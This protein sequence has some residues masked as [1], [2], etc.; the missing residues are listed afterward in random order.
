M[1]AS[2][3]V[4]RRKFIKTT[5][6]AAVAAPIVT[7]MVGFSEVGAPSVPSKKR[8]ALVGTG[9]RGSNAW[10]K[11]IVDRYG[12][13]IELVALCDINKGRL[14]YAK[15]H[16]GT[17]APTYHSSD[18]DKMVKE[19]KPDTIVIG[20]TDC[21]HGKY[22]VR[23]MELGCDVL[24]EKPLVTDE[25]QGQHIVDTEIRTGKKITT[26]F[27]ARFGNEAERIKKILLSGELGKVL[28]A[29]FQEYL[30]IDHGASYYRRWHGKNKFSGSLLVHKASHHFDKMNWWLDSEPETVNAFGKLAFYGKNN[31][32]RGKNCRSCSFRSK[33]DFFW[34]IHKYEDKG[35]YLSGEK[36]DGYLRDGCVWDNEIDA[37]DSMTVEVKYAN[38]VLL[39]Y[40]LNSYMPYEGQLIAFNCEKGRLEIRSYHRQPWEVPNAAEVRIT[41]NFGKT[42]T[43]GIQSGEGVHGGADHKLREKL[44]LP[45]QTDELN[46]IAD[47]RSGLL[48]S[49]IGIA[50]ARSIETQQQVRINDLIKFPVSWGR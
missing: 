2:E 20:T 9:T 3:K 30:D 8:Y 48:S 38:D 44:F 7:P 41:K 39:S 49:L 10:A 17:K 15:G 26:T 14:S 1:G 43:F 50:A 47:S 18:F 6:M 35:F 27:N 16:I 40:S 13:Y 24:C 25:V 19:T 28:S 37:Y 45:D 4:D 34:D 22:I 21:F 32:F 11:P 31:A 33:C 36:E 42:R 46:Q 12:E 5:T 23:A 29:E